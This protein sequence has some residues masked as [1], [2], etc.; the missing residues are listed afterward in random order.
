VRHLPLFD[1]PDRVEQHDD[2]D[3]Q[4]IVDPKDQ[5]SLGDQK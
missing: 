2:I 3:D 1:R 5:N 4:A